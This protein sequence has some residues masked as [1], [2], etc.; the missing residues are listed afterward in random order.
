MAADVESIVVD[1][2]VRDQDVWQSIHSPDEVRSR[3]DADAKLDGFVLDTT[4]EG[5]LG[6]KGVAYALACL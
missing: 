4:G 3:V 1:Y 2:D 5:P 6:L